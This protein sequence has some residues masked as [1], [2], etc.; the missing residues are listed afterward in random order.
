MSSQRLSD[1]WRR[2]RSIAGLLLRSWAAKVSPSERFA[3]AED[4]GAD[5][6]LESRVRRLM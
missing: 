6:D 5:E 3:G 1:A 2:L 4:L